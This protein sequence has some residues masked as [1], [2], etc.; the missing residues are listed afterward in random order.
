MRDCACE[1]IPKNFT[2]V[3]RWPPPIKTIYDTV[4]TP[5]IVMK[6][7]M[8]GPTLRDTGRRRIS[9]G[10][11][12]LSRMK[13]IVFLSRKKVR[14][15][16]SSVVETNIDTFTREIRPIVRSNNREISEIYSHSLIEFRSFVTFFLEKKEKNHPWLLKRIKN[17]RTPIQ[18]ELDYFYHYPVIYYF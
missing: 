10:R 1:G 12:L 5:F 8:I 16:S 13:G 14:C 6:M 18:T 4:Q 9:P 2:S 3:L 15:V 7:S 17:M 11:R